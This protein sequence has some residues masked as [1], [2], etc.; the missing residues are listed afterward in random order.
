M[1]ELE[2]RLAAA[3][4]HY[5]V[6]HDDIGGRLFMDGEDTI[7]MTLAIET[8]DGI[9]QNDALLNLMRDKIKAN[10][11]GFVI[12]DPF[13]STH[14]VNENSNSA[15]QVVVAMLRKLARETDAAIHIIHHVR[16]GNGDD[17]TLTACEAL[18]H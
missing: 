14:E 4:K 8:R 1:F 9:Q 2:L 7:G 16:K 18:A 12:I 10:N 11:I 13:V 3:M 15:I 6:S 5:K 17:A